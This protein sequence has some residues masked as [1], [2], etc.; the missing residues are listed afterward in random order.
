M[1][2]VDDELTRRLRRAQRP[3]DGDGLFEAL[4][5]R[6]SHRE[7][8]RRVQAALLAFAVLAATVVGFVTLTRA[9]RETP[10]GSVASPFPLMPKENGLLAYTDGS[11]LFTI[12]PDGGE[13]SRIRGIPV[14]AWLP[15]W[16]PDGKHLAV[17]IFPPGPGPRELWVANADG[18]NAKKL[19]EADNV[20]KPSWSP[21]GSRLVYAANT[22]EGSAVHIVDSDGSGD[23]IVGEVAQ[24][25]DYFSATF[26][27]DGTQILLDR[28]T[29]VGFGIY[30]MDADGANVRRLS[31]SESDYNPAW[32]PSGLQIA[33]TRQEEGAE[34]DI[35]VMNADGSAVR[36]LTDGPR[37][38]TNLY[39][40][41]APDGTAVAYVSG[42][43]GGPGGLVVMDADGGSPR[44][45]VD[46]GV[47]GIAWQPLPGSL[48]PST[49]VSKGP[50]VSPQPSVSGK[51]EGNNIG[52]GFNLCHD[53]RLGGIDFLGDGTSGTAWIGVPTDDDGTCPRYGQPGRY[54]VA[55]DHT[56]DGI[57]D[58]WLNLPWSCD[59]DCVPYDATDLDGDGSDELIVASYFSIMDYHVM[60]VKPDASGVLRIVPLLVAEPGHPPAGLTAG[61][62]LRIDAGGDAGYGSAIWCD[63]YPSDPVIVWAW[64]LGVVDGNQPSEVHIT[65]LQ[66][67]SDGLVHVVGTND[68][69]ISATENWGYG[70][71]TEP[72]CGVDFH[73]AA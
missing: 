41:F 45:I 13:A 12:S 55:E 72:A 49:S 62:P 42:K 57:A 63:N 26:S 22:Q 3:V 68:Y 32:S 39:P 69:T 40:I 9:F 4:A 16:S 53:E 21:D 60:A 73:P 65:R 52:L 34:S 71:R 64:V 29:D 58:S 18:S 5:R 20:S 1:S 28:G 51:T 38:D 66:V 17:A 7:R 11:S 6:R 50:S 8:V 37:G 10:G 2:K 24:G 19:A 67:R 46:Q 43:A 15:A 54:V 61:E 56:A 27:P 59:V 70:N 33:F 25:E 35:F 36:R 48:E 47:L 23:H 14:G 31:Q 30:V 44:T